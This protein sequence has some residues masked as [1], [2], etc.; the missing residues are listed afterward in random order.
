VIP[1]SD[2][3]LDLIHRLRK[4]EGQIRGLQ[5]MITEQRDC[6]DI[7]TQLSAAGK[8]LDQVGFRMLTSGLLNCLNDPSTSTDVDL[9]E[10]ERLFLE[11]A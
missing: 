3:H 6:R 10:I 2:V 4:V 9:A 1:P 5:Q 11:L 8:A 7:V